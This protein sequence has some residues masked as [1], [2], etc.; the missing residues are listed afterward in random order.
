M[1]QII[2]TELITYYNFLRYP[3]YEPSS[4]DSLSDKWQRFIVL[5]LF[6]LLV[7]LPIY[8]LFAE[9][10]ITYITGISSVP[11]VVKGDFANLFAMCIL[12]PIGEECM[13]RLFLTSN[14]SIISIWLI[15][16]S[17]IVYLCSKGTIIALFFISVISLI[18]FFLLLQPNHQLITRCGNWLKAHFFAIFYLSATIFAIAHAFNLELYGIYPI[19]TYLS[20]VYITANIS[21]QFIGGL[22]LGYIRIKNG[23]GFSIFYHVFWNIIAAIAYYFFINP[24]NNS[25]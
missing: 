1:L 3:N 6:E 22:L 2:K 18:G 24:P 9:K 13:F 11:T 4:K 21:I 12:A 15:L 19:P 8:I 23:M 10:F 16:S 14:K 20:V 5:F 17:W 7:I 25:I